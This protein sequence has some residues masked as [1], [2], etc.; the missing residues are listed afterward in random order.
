MSYHPILLGTENPH[1]KKQWQL[2]MVGWGIT[3][4]L[5][6]VIHN[7]IMEG[8]SGQRKLSTCQSDETSDVE[9]E[10]TDWLGMPILGITRAPEYVCGTG[11]IF[12]RK[13]FSSAPKLNCVP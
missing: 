1:I 3:V 12:I 4:P 11:N 13:H 7:K 2:Y 9:K 8:T 10:Q 6:L 5:W